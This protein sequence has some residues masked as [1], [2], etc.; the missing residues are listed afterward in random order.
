MTHNYLD[1]DLIRAS[2][3]TGDIPVAVLTLNRPDKLNAMDVETRRRLAAAI[4]EFGSDDIVRGII[5]TGTGRAFSAGED[6]ASVPT[7]FAEMHEAVRTFHDITR[8]ILQTTVPVIAAVNGLAVGGA[9]EITLCCD[10]RIGTPNTTY[11]Q[12]ENHRGIIISNAS[13]LL[14]ER[15]VR[16]HAMRIVLGSNR[17]D[18]DDAL[19]IGLL[20]EVVPADRLVDR[21]KE[22]VGQW[23]WD[24]RIT[25]LHLELLRPALADVEAAFAREDSAAEHAWDCGAFTDGVTGFWA[26]KTAATTSLIEGKTT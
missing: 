5:L 15:L 25:A 23:N 19:R 21:A 6:L 8:A 16:S 22:I 17:I 14:L 13:S 3:A 12:P 20:D 2:A 9:S 7:T 24:P 1:V 11:F 4:R 10:A 26:S 18:A